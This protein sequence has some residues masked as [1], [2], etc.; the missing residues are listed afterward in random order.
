MM[1]TLLLHQ[2]HLLL[3]LLHLYHLLA[4]LFL[5]LSLRMKTMSQLSQTTQPLHPL[6]S[7]FTFLNLDPQPLLAES[8]SLKSLLLLLQSLHLHQKSPWRVVEGGP[9]RAVQRPQSCCP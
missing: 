7:L 8:Q 3:N 1:M 9:P 2:L 6:L 4:L 5:S